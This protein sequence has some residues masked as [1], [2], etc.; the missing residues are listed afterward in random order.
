[1]DE[2]EEQFG[3]FRTDVKFDFTEA[4]SFSAYLHSCAL[5]VD[6][7]AST[8]RTAL[9][10]AEEGF[11]GYYANLFAANM[12]NAIND[13]TTLGTVFRK[14]EKGVNY[15][16]EEAR[17]ENRRRQICRE[18]VAKVKSRWFFT[19]VH[20]YFAGDPDYPNFDKSNLLPVKQPD[21]TLAKRNT[22][23]SGPK[24]TG[25]TSSAYPE[26]LKVASGLLSNTMKEIVSVS[27]FSS[28]LNRFTA[29]CRYGHFEVGNLVSNIASW[30]EA[31][32][33][34][35][36]WLDNV[37]EAFARAGSEGSLSSLPD[38]A[39][40]ESLQ[41]AN[42]HSYRETIDISS[43]QLAGIDKSTGYLEDPVNAT[44][45]SFVEPE[46]DFS[47]SGASAS[48]ALSR[49]Y[50]STVDFSGVFG[51]GWF[52]ILDQR[53]E[54]ETEQVSWFRE[55]GRQVVFPRLGESFGRAVGDNFWLA[56]ESVEAI[57]G[58]ERFLD[59]EGHDFLTVR[60][61]AGSCWVFSLSGQW[62]GV[63][64][65]PGSCIQVVRNSEGLVSA[66]KHE[67]GR[68]IEIRY[69]AGLVSAAVSSAGRKV[70]Y[71]YSN[72]LFLCEVR[73]GSSSRFYEWN[74]DG[75]ISRVLSSSG[76]VEVDNT[77]D[78]LGRVVS[79]VTPFGRT[80]TF[81]Y[82][83]SNVTVVADSDG[84]R[85]NSWIADAKGRCIGIV[86]SDGNRQSMLHDAAGNLVQSVGRDGA[87]TVNAYDKRGRLTRTILPSK[88]EISYSWDAFDRLATVV[89][90]N[91]SIVRYEYEGLE[92]NPSKVFDP[93]GG[94]HTLE[95]ADGLL[96]STVDPT[97]VRLDF[98][99]DTFGDLVSVTNSAG[100]CASLIRDESGRVVEQMT[101]LG[102]S[103]KY[104]YDSEGHL[105]RIVC[106]DGAVWNFVYDSAGRVV[107]SIDPEGGEITLGYGLHGQLVRRVDAM[108]RVLERTFDDLGNVSTL[109][110]P[111]G[112]EFSFAYDAL[113]R[114]RSLT[115]PDGGIWEHEYDA[116][117][118]LSRVVDPTGRVVRQ[119]VSAFGQ[120]VRSVLPDGLA[121]Y[122]IDFDP[123]GRISKQIDVS[124]TESVL[125]YDAAGNVV[126]VLDANAG[127]TL[128][129]RDLAGRLIQQVSPEGRV[130]SYSYNS[131]G[132]LESVELP[133][134]DRE[135]YRYD[136]DLRL[137]SKVFASG[138]EATYEY[139]SCSRLV[140]SE[141]PGQGVSIFKYDR[142]GR[143]IYSR[144]LLTGVRHFKYDAAGYLI[145]AVNG[146]GGQTS[147]EYDSRGNLVALRDAAGGVSRWAYN[148]VGQ[149]IS[150]T[151]SLGRVTS[152]TYDLAGRQITQTGADG[153]CLSFEYDVNGELSEVHADGR[154][155]TRYERDLVKR[156]VKLVDHTRPGALNPTV[157]EL[158]YDRL[159]HLVLR[160]T[161]DEGKAWST[162]WEYDGDALRTAY[163][164]AEGV[165][166]EYQR[167]SLGRVIRL[168]NE[169]V[170]EVDFG[171]DPDGNL[172]SY[173]FAGES[174]EGV[175]AGGWLVEQTLRGF[176]Q[177]SSSRVE[178]DIWGRVVRVESSSGAV[179]YEY[180]DANDLVRAVS[181]DGHESNW[182]YETSGRLITSRVGGIST[183]FVYDAGGQLRS[184][185]ISDGRQVEYTY[186]L[187]GRR[188][189]EEWSGSYSS[190]RSYSWDERGWLKGVE[191]V[192]QG[193][194]VRVDTWINGLGELTDVGGMSLTWDF[195][196]P[197]PSLDSFAG[198]GI[199]QLPDS[200]V[201]QASGGEI[202]RLF[203]LGG[204]LLNPYAPTPGVNL[205]GM[206][207]GVEINPNGGI[208]ISGLQWMGVR[209]YDPSSVGF[210][211][212]DPLEALSGSMWEANPYNYLGNNPLNLSDPL[213]TRPV[214]DAQLKAQNWGGSFWERNKDNILSGETVFGALFLTAGIV[215]SFLV[216]GG[217]IIGLALAGALTNTGFSILS[218]KLGT[219]TVDWK[220]VA[221]DA[222]IGGISGAAMGGV[223]QFAT[224]KGFGTLSRE[225]FENT[226]G[227]VIEGA[228]DTADDLVHGR[229]F[230][231]SKLATGM[232]SGLLSGSF[233]GYGSAKLGQHI[234]LKYHSNPLSAAVSSF[235]EGAVQDGTQY[236]AEYLTGQ[237][238]KFSVS[239]F[240]E[241]SVAGGFRSALTSQSKELY[242]KH[243]DLRYT[244]SEYLSQD[245][246]S[247][248]YGPRRTMRIDRDTRR[249]GDSYQLDELVLDSGEK[250][251]TTEYKGMTS[252]GEHT[253]I[254]VEQHIGVD[255]ASS[256]KVVDRRLEK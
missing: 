113:S 180:D 135:F 236:T 230:S 133:S 111:D 81:S 136:A 167:D 96:L 254:T 195:A 137:V 88:A 160:R 240:A 162:S 78:S 219:G 18:Y 235:T 209:V 101:A 179:C 5:S 206:P 255:G 166:T 223:G 194:S 2:Y 55:D 120:K 108:G 36:R 114:L 14:L 37:G 7:Y 177:V 191:N 174:Y 251:V 202:S 193:K 203:S 26:K 154:L 197:L 241:S 210:L 115:S 56:R 22:D 239:G 213:G 66:L 84:S 13:S 138:E 201:M 12:R 165:R 222:A 226:T 234:R 192:E 100:S 171:Y 103:T 99:Y 123:Y 176:G 141:I 217:P 248:E 20:Y 72:G 30:I 184:Q 51:R 214:T 87:V 188:A 24:W 95:W 150:Y 65:G 149:V 59:D 224:N 130:T 15:L 157:H 64:S 155:L 186:D 25:G 247:P 90:G 231:G 207:A 208:G 38:T 46:V 116:D 134:K 128:L 43:P 205:P 147:Y 39:I 74:E 112:A 182:V 54:I 204:D 97:G 118:N 152:A 104:S 221:L 73:A 61:N 158:T 121:S 34:D 10:H 212:R 127:L 11:S 140:R 233:G 82:L 9:S 229:G 139:D 256:E 153:I 67:F 75:L 122:G 4:S 16:I 117:G 28:R 232:G 168:S 21:F 76:V 146:L 151:D 45:G 252:A 218:Q 31:G 237:R 83:P 48:L 216:P 40:R 161:E 132:L 106:P 242:D 178:R 109:H 44:T 196:S 60:D 125:T 33:N 246:Y 105:S 3:D 58:A 142:C 23:D 190:K 35:S 68:F 126:E 50:N 17:K 71:L 144:D 52:S 62:L 198:K 131:C 143:L 119:E 98:A 93:L 94:V 183:D 80:V 145:K 86:D 170:G 124:G 49:T 63:S 159:G 32:K 245:K 47:F 8:C 228:R 175:Y 1:M 57:A 70:E 220:T 253:S 110:L 156:Q 41:G 244:Y 89:A 53:L 27:E 107:K 173:S 172:T 215:A 189:S 227:S 238:D 225:M 163:V 6:K 211:S 200:L 199:V 69:S 85:S 29:R 187:V 129:R 79:Q 92:R 91:G 148:E 19:R 249:F 250:I 185:K 169:L 181:D 102:F 77:Y 42:I 243:M 164:S